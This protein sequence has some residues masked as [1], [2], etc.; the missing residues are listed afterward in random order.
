MLTGRLYL[1]FVKK[2]NIA[3][4]INSWPERLDLPDML[5]R[6]AKEIGC[7]FTIDT[8]AH[9]VM[10]MDNMFYGVSVARRGWLDKDDIIN[11]QSLKKVSEWIEGK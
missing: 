5:V 9:A 7:K 1:S 3:L 10:Q 11:T 8:D 4:E 2:K 6:E